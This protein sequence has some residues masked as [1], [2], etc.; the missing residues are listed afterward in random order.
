MEDI[1]GR[2]QSIKL[3]S[4]TFLKVYL[5][6]SPSDILCNNYSKGLQESIKELFHMLILVL[7][8]FIMVII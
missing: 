8:E 3:S 2:S 6:V 7:G 4:Q 1:E 5:A